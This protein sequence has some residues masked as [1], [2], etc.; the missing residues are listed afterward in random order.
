MQ[1][2]TGAHLRSEMSDTFRLDLKG[3]CLGD[4]TAD[5]NLSKGD[6]LGRGSQV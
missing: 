1:S 3:G 4:P 6:A 5:L 2:N